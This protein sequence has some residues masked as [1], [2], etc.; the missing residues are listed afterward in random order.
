MSDV[1]RDKATGGAGSHSEDDADT[2]QALRTRLLERARALLAA[3]HR[4]GV[5]PW[6]GRRYDY[7]CPSAHSYPFQWFWDS[8]F[9]A[10]ALTRIDVELAKA[11][12]RSLAQ[13][14]RPDGFMP[15][16][17][18]WQPDREVMARQTL[19]LS[20]PYL[21]A[22]IQPPVIAL[23]V[24]RVYRASGDERFRDELLPVVAAFFRWL[25]DNRDPDG[26]ELIAVVQPDESG[27]DASPKYDPLLG[28]PGDNDDLVRAINAIY[29]RYEP[30]GNNDRRI[31]AADV[32]VVEDVLVNSIY[33]QGLQSLAR[34]TRDPSEAAEYRAWAG[35]VLAALM[36][37]CYDPV[38]GLFLDLLGTEERRTEVNTISALF[39]LI[40]EGLD[41]AVAE[42]LVADHLRNP[43]EYAL[44]YPA[45]SVAADA[46]G[47]NPDHPHGFIWRGPTWVN[48]NWFLAH[49]LHDRGYVEDA[50]RIGA[51]TR[52]L[53]D[54]QGFRECYNPYTGEGQN[55]SGFGWTSLVVD[56]PD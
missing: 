14:A 53:V 50:R 42:R 55:A 2:E 4:E 54:A 23:A 43:A 9:H 5:S 25:R 29:A 51:A 15:H 34:L 19:R 20:T 17:I 12:L 37:K 16:I 27:V 10:I 3:N 41:P 21:S 39:P 35:R 38:R 48:S 22:S 7:T 44:P 26:D 28:Y 18:F 45:P 33:A 36:E 24:E 56:F 30:L 13:G 52:A 46:P 6:E 32:F 47:F 1:D 31:I 11:E 8:C 49:A 40:V